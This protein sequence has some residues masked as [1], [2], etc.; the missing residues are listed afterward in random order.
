MNQKFS[1]T[2]RKLKLLL[3]LPLI[4][5]VF[6]AFAHPKYIFEQ[7]PSKSQM[8]SPKYSWKC[9]IGK[10]VKDDG[11]PLFGAIISVLERPFGT[12]TNATG[13]F[14]IVIPE[15]S[16]LSIAFLG[17]K[18][19]RTKPVFDKEMIIKLKTEKIG[20]NPIEIYPPNYCETT[21]TLSSIN[22]EK[23][24]IDQT[25]KAES[26]AIK[27]KK[28]ETSDVQFVE[29]KATINLNNAL[30]VKNDTISPNLKLED[31]DPKSIWSIRLLDK[32]NAIKKYGTIAENGV[33][34]ISTEM[35]VYQIVEEMPEFPGGVTNLRKVLK[36]NLIYPEI[37]LKKGIKGTVLVSFVVDEGGFAANVIIEKGLDT[38]LDNEVLQ[39]VKNLPK[40]KPGKQRGMPVKVTY[41]LPII[42]KL[43]ANYH[44][45]SVEKLKQMK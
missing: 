7:I 41:E 21:K 13:N 1:P 40:W 16:T 8:A 22:C 23:K 35:E 20:I 3:T 10:V 25:D 19:L 15:N 44:F 34:V 45:Q 24:D 6:I 31:I 17:L 2:F 33:I 14:E 36:T 11:S 9:V 12:V 27:N 38:L 18:I 37:A 29:K 39:A 4:A 32:E 28:N 42:F 30:I 26:Q 43:P 5:F